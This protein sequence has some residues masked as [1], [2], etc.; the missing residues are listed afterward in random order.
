MDN[1]Q[2]LVM[3]V[4]EPILVLLVMGVIALLARLLW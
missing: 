2:V 1:D 4:L 3:G